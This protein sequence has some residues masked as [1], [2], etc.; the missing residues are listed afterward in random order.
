MCTEYVVPFRFVYHWHRL[1]LS[2]DA[3]YRGKMVLADGV[4]IRG[5]VVHV[6]KERKAIVVGENPSSLVWDCTTRNTGEVD[7]QNANHLHRV[8]PAMQ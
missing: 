8:P 6:V 5:V 7:V 2:T 1:H 3:N 4:S